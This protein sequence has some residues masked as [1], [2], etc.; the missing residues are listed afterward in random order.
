MVRRLRSPSPSPLLAMDLM[1]ESKTSCRFGMTRMVV[2]EFVRVRV[3][4]CA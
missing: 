3:L 1:S 4:V 2:C